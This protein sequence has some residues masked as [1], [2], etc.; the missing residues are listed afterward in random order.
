MQIF[1]GNHMEEMEEDREILETQNMIEDNFLKNL[2]KADNK[3]ATEIGS[4]VTE[5]VAVASTLPS[6]VNTEELMLNLFEVRDGLIESFESVGLNTTVSSNLATNINKV[7]SCIKHIGGKVEEFIPL[8]HVSGLQAPD[9]NRSANKVI[10]TTQHCY[11]LGEIT[12]ADIKDDGRTIAIDFEGKE[13][14]ISYKARGTI[15]ASKTWRGN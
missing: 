3:M 14:D 8:D 9:L 15:T 6:N 7:G 11:T 1:G 12:K 5:T 10:A 4:A 13:G 2:K